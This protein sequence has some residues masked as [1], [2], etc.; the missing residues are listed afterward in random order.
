MNSLSSVHH[1]E[2]TWTNADY[3]STEPYK[4]YWNLKNNMYIFIQE[5]AFENVVCKMSADLFWPQCV[6]LHFALTHWYID[7]YIN[8]LRPAVWYHGSW[9]TLVQIRAC[10]LMAQSHHLNQCWLSVNWIPWNTFKWKTDAISSKQNTFVN[11]VC[12]MS[13]IL[14][15]P[16]CINSLWPSDAISRHRSGSTLAQVIA[17]C[18][19][20]PS[21]Y[22][23]QCWLII[24]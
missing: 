24:S 21:Y 7:Q 13:A 3:L 11:T 8:S 12:K 10:C 15:R 5:V 2:I 14:F 9:S 19:T 1:Q 6:H 20:A 4:F 16:Q 22:L 17:C 18:L 23:N